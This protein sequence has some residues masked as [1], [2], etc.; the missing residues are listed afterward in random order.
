MTNGDRIRQMSDEELAFVLATDTCP[1]ADCT[2]ADLCKAH[3]HNCIA[4]WADWL[5]KEAKDGN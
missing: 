3:H 5:R 4:C 2:P 1:N